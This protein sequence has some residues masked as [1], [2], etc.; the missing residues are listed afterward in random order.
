M[1]ISGISAAAHAFLT[2]NGSPFTLDDGTKRGLF[3]IPDVKSFQDTQTT[4][5]S[6]YMTVSPH[7]TRQIFKVQNAGQAADPANQDVASGTPLSNPEYIRKS[8]GYIKRVDIAQSTVAGQPTDGRL[9]VVVNPD[10]LAP[11]PIWWSTTTNQDVVNNSYVGST[12]SP[13][14]YAFDLCEQP[15]MHDFIM[16]AAALARECQSYRI[17]GC[18]VKAWVSS[19]SQ[20]ANGTICGGHFT[21]SL[22]QYKGPHSDL[23]NNGTT[24]GYKFWG[25]AYV[26]PDIV[27]M[28]V[29]YP[30]AGAVGT[31]QYLFSQA[32][33]GVAVTAES[34]SCWSRT[35]YDGLRGGNTGV[36]GTCYID[37]SSAA[38][39][40]SL[41]G[42]KTTKSQMYPASEGIT[43]RW[44]DTQEYAFKRN[45]PRCLVGPSGLTYT[46]GIPAADMIKGRS[47]NWYDLDMVTVGSNTYTLVC[48]VQ[49]AREY[50]EGVFLDSYGVAGT[51]H[52]FDAA[53]LRHTVTV[54]TDN[55]TAVAPYTTTMIFAGNLVAGHPEFAVCS[56]R[57]NTGTYD[58]TGPVPYD[59]AFC[60]VYAQ[61][62]TP[63]TTAQMMFN[64][65]AAN[66][67]NGLWVDV[68][69]V[70]I[71]QDVT[72]QVIWHVEY[73]PLRGSIGIPQAS[74]VDPDWPRITMLASNPQVFP[75]FSKGHSFFKSLWHAFK[76]AGRVVV[77]ILGGASKIA[78]M[79]PDPRAQEFAKATQAAATGGGAAMNVLSDM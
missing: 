55:T 37:R 38:V 6:G 60:P 10:P 15:G 34:F 56:N 70:D 22:S 7:A 72:L 31:P 19:T 65:D 44:V 16:Q 1:P 71:Q 17:V 24:H 62:D 9:S 5:L 30:S 8:T 36:Y 52:P 46:N 2:A 21:P 77:K 42:A 48:P 63:L 43:V 47:P 28:K 73:V 75:F 11:N 23:A 35:E 57:C 54:A 4:T 45:V 74:P 26:D 25:P 67:G 12:T 29:Y 66:F 41:A 27:D 14:S 78:S 68:D 53:V 59:Q 33:S 51:T 13:N 18:A 49:G 32:P 64:D 40:A 3:K 69:G 76:K 20:I 58:S 61:G 39:R 79:I 50:E